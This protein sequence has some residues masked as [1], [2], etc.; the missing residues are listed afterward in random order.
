MIS[1]IDH[2]GSWPTRRCLVSD[3]K[4]GM[5]LAVRYGRT[6]LIKIVDLKPDPQWSG[7][8]IVVTDDNYRDGQGCSYPNHSAIGIDAYE[9]IES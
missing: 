5:A 7:Y 6:K 8:T 4:V 9:G 1:E 2:S 3:L